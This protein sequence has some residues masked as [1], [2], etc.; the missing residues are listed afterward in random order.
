MQDATARAVGNVEFIWAS[1]RE[2]FSGVEANAMGCHIIT[3]A[4]DV[5]KKLP[6]FATKTPA[7][8]SLM[9]VK[10]SREDAIAVGLRLAVPASRA[11][12]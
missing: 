6:A 1:T 11:A 3:A 2:V 8:L 4:A 7:E 9:A 5:L 12:E 10:L